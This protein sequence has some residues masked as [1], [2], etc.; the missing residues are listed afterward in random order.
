MGKADYKKRKL[1][2]KQQDNL[3]ECKE[4]HGAHN[5]GRKKWYKKYLNRK[6]RRKDNKRI[7][8]EEE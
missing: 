7:E 1:R 5:S 6:Y 4:L 2:D 3:I 8:R